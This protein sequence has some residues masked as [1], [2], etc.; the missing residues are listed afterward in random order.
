[1]DNYKA[2]QTPDGLRYSFEGRIQDVISLRE[3][4]GEIPFLGVVSDMTLNPAILNAFTL[5]TGLQLD[6]DA[7]LNEMNGLSIDQSYKMD[8]VFEQFIC[9]VH[10]KIWRGAERLVN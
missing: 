8:Y 6:D 1:M 10:D 9:Y 5:E 7:Y 2:T 4:K 3:Y